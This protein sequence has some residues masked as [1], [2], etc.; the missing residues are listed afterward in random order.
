MSDLE[1]LLDKKGMFLKALEDLSKFR[2]IMAYSNDPEMQQLQQVFDQGFT[3]LRDQF[4]K[5]MD[6]KA[7]NMTTGSTQSRLR[8]N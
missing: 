7:A 8:R 1:K 4:Q 5:A 2:S 6:E 3:S